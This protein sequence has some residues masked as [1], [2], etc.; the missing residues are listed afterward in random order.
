MTKPAAAA[1]TGASLDPE[2]L[3]HFEKRLLE[4]RKRTLREMGRLTE[5]FGT[6]EQAADGDLTSYPFHQA[7]MGTDTMEQEKNFL[8]ASQEG[9]LVLE[10]DE[11]LRRLYGKPETFGRCERCGTMIPYDRLDALPQA[12]FCIPCM[13]REERGAGAA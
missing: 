11:A 1:D 2:Q 13:Q 9:R 12:R 8:L 10:I 5:S 6:S 4:E 3:A 7:D